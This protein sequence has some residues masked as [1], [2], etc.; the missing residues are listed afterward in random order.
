VASDFALPAKDLAAIDKRVS[1]TYRIPK[2]RHL[3]G[4]PE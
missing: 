3:R 1:E 4:D 2:M